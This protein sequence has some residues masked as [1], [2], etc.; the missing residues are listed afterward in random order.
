MSTTDVLDHEMYYEQASE[1]G[2]TP[3]D[4]IVTYLEEQSPIAYTPGAIVETAD[5]GGSVQNTPADGPYPFV[6][7]G[8]DSGDSVYAAVAMVPKGYAF[9][10]GGVNRLR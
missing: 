8:A 9:S 7:S 6:Q 3:V 4:I 2:V 5:D 1:E 10:E